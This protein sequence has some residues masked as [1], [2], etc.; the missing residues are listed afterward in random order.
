[1]VHDKCNDIH[2]FISFMNILDLPYISFPK[3]I[4]L[5]ITILSIKIGSSIE[6]D[7]EIHSKANGVYLQH[8]LYTYTTNKNILANSKN[9]WDKKRH[10]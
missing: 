8:S 9:L 1:M 10:I 7:N 3:R 5:A 4:S 2:S 6:S